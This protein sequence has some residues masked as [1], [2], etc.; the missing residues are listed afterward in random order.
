MKPIAKEGSRVGDRPGWIGGYI[1]LTEWPVFFGLPSWIVPSHPPKMSGSGKGL[2]GLWLYRM[3]EEEWKL[4]DSYNS[5]RQV[6]LIII[7]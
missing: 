7:Y 2:L 6:F 3:G 5:D 4:K 1:N